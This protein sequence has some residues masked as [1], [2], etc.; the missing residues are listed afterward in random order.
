[1]GIPAVSP[2]PPVIGVLVKAEGQSHGADLEE[3]LGK[4]RVPQGLG[5]RLKL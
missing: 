5:A 4:E 1:M 3:E 2:P